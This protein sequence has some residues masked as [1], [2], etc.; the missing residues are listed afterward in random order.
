MIDQAR[1][2]LDFTKGLII[3][4]PDNKSTILVQLGSYFLTGLKVLV[5][6][7]M[8]GMQVK[9]VVNYFSCVITEDLQK[10]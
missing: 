4:M 7:V 6:L 9:I 10:S 2:L 3:L 8:I 5:V 1:K